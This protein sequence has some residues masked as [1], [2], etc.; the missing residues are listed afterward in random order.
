MKSASQLELLR[1]HITERIAGLVCGRLLDGIKFFRNGVIASEFT[2]REVKLALLL[3]KI[4]NP[5]EFYIAAC[6]DDDARDFVAKYK[7]RGSRSTPAHHMLV[8][9]ANIGRNYF[10]DNPV[11]AFPVAKGEFW[12]VDRLYFDLTGF[13]ISDAVILTHS[14]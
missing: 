1:P 5:D 7:A 13:D 10:K 2:R 4:A 14:L 12:I 9:T 3:V 6:F 11:L 8:T